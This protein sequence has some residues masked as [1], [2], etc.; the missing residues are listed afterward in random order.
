M[1]TPENGIWLARATQN[2]TTLL[3]SLKRDSST[4]HEI[5]QDFEAGYSNVDIVC[6]YEQKYGP[7]HIQVCLPS[8]LFSLD[9][10][11]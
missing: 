4:L 8:H 7:A 11:G 3:E 10:F 9:K 6:F 1:G 2:D 5:A